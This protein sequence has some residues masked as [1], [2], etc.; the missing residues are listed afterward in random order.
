MK[1]TAATPV[2]ILLLLSISLDGAT[3]AHGGAHAAADADAGFATAVSC[4]A[5]EDCMSLL[6]EATCVGVVLN[7]ATEVPEVA[8]T[9]HANTTT[10][11]YNGG[12]CLKPW[13][14]GNH[15]NHWICD[16]ETATGEFTG[17]DCNT[18]VTITEDEDNTKEVDILEEGHCQCA[19]GFMGDAC[20]IPVQDCGHHNLQCQYGGTCLKPWTNDNRSGQWVCDCPADR[21]GRECEESLL[22]AD[23]E[24][25]VEKSGGSKFGIAVLVLLILLGAGGACYYYAKRGVRRA[26]S[27]A[28]AKG[29][30]IVDQNNNGP[31]HD[32][33][34]NSTAESAKPDDMEDV[35]NNIIL[36]TPTPKD[37]DYEK[38]FV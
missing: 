21:T 10:V 35:D 13:S 19:S 31:Y 33:T 7:N 38:E 6:N 11:C 28:G 27:D 30:D 24:N 22:P 34:P 36:D 14:N 17:P 12:K 8:T 4:T 5:D 37:E 3:A 15:H 9:C 32:D 20:E 1:L 29:Q 26:A 2:Y 16:C 23:E 18:P 25:D